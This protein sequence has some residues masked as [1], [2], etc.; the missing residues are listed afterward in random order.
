VVLLFGATRDE[1]LYLTAKEITRADCI[2]R[3]SLIFREYPTINFL[4]FTEV[5]SSSNECIDGVDYLV[6]LSC[7]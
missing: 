5:K 6:I 1:D 4:L 7:E 3:Q 2:G